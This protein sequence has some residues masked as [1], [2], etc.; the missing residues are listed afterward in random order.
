MYIQRA[1]FP[2]C[3][4]VQPLCVSEAGNLI[5]QVT[6]RQHVLTITLI[7]PA[8]LRVSGGKLLVRPVCCDK[9][10]A[11]EE[12]YILASLLCVLVNR[13]QKLQGHLGLLL[14]LLPALCFYCS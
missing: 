5:C 13:N 9:V 11:E 10:K 12:G 3:L 6:G 14:P 7:F 1:S 4:T 8:S 2:G